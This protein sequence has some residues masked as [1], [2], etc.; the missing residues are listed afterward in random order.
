MTNDVGTSIREE[1]H[2]VDPHDYCRTPWM[3]RRVSV[4]D[5]SLAFPHAPHQH[6]VSS[7]E[8][9]K[10]HACA[11]LRTRPHIEDWKTLGGRT[12]KSLYLRQVGGFPSRM[13]GSVCVTACSLICGREHCSRTGDERFVSR[14]L[15]QAVQAEDGVPADWTEVSTRRA[16]RGADDAEAAEG[17][18][19]A[20]EDDRHHVNIKADRALHIL[21]GVPLGGW[22][23][24]AEVSPP[25]RACGGL[26][27]ARRG[28]S[29]PSSR[30]VVCSE[31]VRGGAGEGVRER[32]RRIGAVVWGWTVPGGRE[33][34]EDGGGGGAGRAGGR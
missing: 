34:D 13:T 29:A 12:P 18:A 3:W 28:E 1:V 26:E 16:A 21:L 5:Q 8:Q 17:V 32:L 19:T 27:R 11:R 20:L 24:A 6:S 31:R 14:L 30:A 15:T 10:S 7:F 23:N 33:R 4:E 25:H 22:R 9:V 2:R